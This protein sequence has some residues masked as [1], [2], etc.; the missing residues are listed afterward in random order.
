MTDRVSIEVVDG[1]ANVR[2]ARPEKINA[3]DHPMFEAIAAAITRIGDDPRIRCVV[4]SGL[5]RGFCVGIDLDSL[6]TNP[7]L[8]DLLSRTH[9]IANLFQQAAWG[10]RCLSVPVIAAVHGFAFG[11]GFQ[12]M[13]GADIRIA[14]PDM[15]LSMMEIRWGLAPDVAGIALLRGLVRDDVAREIVFTGR[16]FTGEEAASMGIVT[17][18]A[19]DPHAEAM[20]LARSIAASSPAAIKAA[21]RLLN[22][23]ADADNATILLAESEEQ[24]KLLAS[25]GHAETIAAQRERRAP[26]FP[27]DTE[28][29]G[30]A[31]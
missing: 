4:L 14:A 10:W 8:R 3:L 5:G 18:V 13:L 20:A 24:A 6:E 26:V 31:S 25:A 29:R 19:A 17:R 2:L 30:K 23:S 16:K 22:F 7:T 27:D 12:I 1:I 21:K 15:Q 9:G 28:L 11:G